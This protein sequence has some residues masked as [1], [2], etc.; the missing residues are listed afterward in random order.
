[1][2]RLPAPTASMVHA[3]AVL[4]QPRKRTSTRISCIYGP[5]PSL[6]DTFFQGFIPKSGF[7]IIWKLWL[8]RIQKYHP[9]NRPWSAR[10]SSPNTFF[11]ARV[12]GG[13]SPFLLLLIFFI[14]AFPDWE[15]KNAP[16][17]AFLNIVWPFTPSGRLE[18]SWHSMDDDAHH[19]IEF[20]ILW[21]Q[22]W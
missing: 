15:Y 4:A 22:F 13:N 3:G 2:S 12:A 11:S 18:T 19:L 8:Q 20:T 1:M 16:I 10:K 5:H 17:L 21:E 14:A 6:T 7:Y 9:Q